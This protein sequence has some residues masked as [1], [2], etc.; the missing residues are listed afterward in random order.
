M[1][2][3]FGISVSNVE[4]AIVR[5]ARMQAILRLV[6]EGVRS[7]RGQ[8]LVALRCECGQLGC[9]QLIELTRADYRA[10]RANPRRFAVVPG[11]EVLEIETTVE[12]HARYAVVEVHD[13]I[14]ARVVDQTG[15]VRSTDE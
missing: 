10:V 1:P 5:L 13:Q 7:R 11:H 14:A 8:Q 9:N 2:F 6:N 4:R 15:P 12:R 3:A